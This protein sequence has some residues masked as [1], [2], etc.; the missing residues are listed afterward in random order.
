MTKVFIIQGITGS[1][2][3][4]LAN[5]LAAQLTNK[6]RKCI[7]LSKDDLRYVDGVYVFNSETEPEIEKMYFRL[8]EGYILSKKYEYI[9]LDNTHLNLTFV[10]KTVELLDKLKAKHISLMLYPDKDLAVHVNGNVHGVSQEKVVKQY[11]DW[12]NSIQEFQGK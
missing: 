12:F 5:K 11:N 9:I 7:I 3:S 4:G 8:L 2:K 10:R 1:G 6:I